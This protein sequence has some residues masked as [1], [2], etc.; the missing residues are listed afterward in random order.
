LQALWTQARYDL[1]VT[2]IV[3]ANR[4]YRILQGELAGVGAANPGRKALDMLD[5][6]RPDLDWVKMAEGMGVEAAKVTDC[7]GLQ[8][9]LAAGLAST[10]PYL[11]EVML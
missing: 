1:D 9:A 10:S 4:A 11:I 5:L 2:T 7:E 3:F 8:K 6:S